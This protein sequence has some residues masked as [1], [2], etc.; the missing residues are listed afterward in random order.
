MA[1]GAFPAAKLG[2]LALKQISKPI[3][4]VLKTRAKSSPFFRKY[5]CMPPAQFYNY[6]EVK[7]KML[8]LNLGK[9]TAVPKLTEAMAI[10]LGANLLGE[11]IIF[12]IGAGLLILEY[13][14]QSRKELLK[15]QMIMQ[16]KMELQA[17]LNELAFQA[18]RQ[19]TQIRE[20]TR[21]IADLDSRSWTPKIL[22]DL[23]GRKKAQLEERG[24]DNP[25]E[26]LPEKPKRTPK[27]ATESSDKNST[28]TA[29]KTAQ[30]SSK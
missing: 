14:R 21:V 16:E 2:V 4:N 20:L 25:L 26:L 18:E 22:N 28:D 9:P 15:E 1:V 7:M 30:T 12:A 3:A 29:T 6:M 24:E 23:V 11:T 27:K 19:D 10:E 13:Q 8:A 17:T 5:I